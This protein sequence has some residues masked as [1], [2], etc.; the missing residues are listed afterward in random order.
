MLQDGLGDFDGIR[1]I[2]PSRAK[3]LRAMGISSLRDL[4]C[5]FPQS[6]E[7]HR[8][9]LTSDGRA[10]ETGVAEGIIS[11]CPGSF[12]F[13]GTSRV[14]AVLETENQSIRL[15]WFNQPW[16]ARSL[17][18]KTGIRL[19]GR[20]TR[21]D[22]IP[23]MVN[24]RLINDED[25]IPVYRKIQGIPGKMLRNWMEIALEKRHVL[26]PEWMPEKVIHDFHLIS[27]EE[28]VYQ[29]HFPESDQ[30]LSAARRRLNCDGMITYLSYVFRH[31]QRQDFG[32]P[33]QITAA[34]EDEYWN[35]LPFHPTEGQRRALHDIAE[36]LT[37]RRSMKR[38]L[39][40]DV[41]CGKTAVAFGAIYL[42]WKNGHQSSMMA[43]TEILAR[44]HYL[45][46]AR[47][48]EPL[49]IHCALL[50]SDIRGKERKEILS[51]LEKGQ[52]H[53][54]FGTHALISQ[55]VHFQD[56]Q[57]TITDEQHRFGVLQR[58]ALEKKGAVSGITYPHVL[59]MSATPIPRS[60]ALILY[61]DLEITVIDELPAGRIPVKTRIVPEEK[62][63]D[64]YRFLTDVVRQGRQVYMVCP[65]VE[66]TEA[67]SDKEE[68]HPQ[69]SVQ[70][71]Y[72]DLKHGALSGLKLGIT[73]GNQKSDE[74]QNVLDR[75]MQGEIQ[76]L[77]STTVIEVGVN[78]P[79]ASIMIIENAER[80][81]LSQLHQLRG[82]V[83]RG[84]EESWC[85]LMTD[86]EE[87]LRILCDTTDGFLISRKDLEIRG[88]GDLMG[89]RQ[90][91]APVFPGVQGDLRLLGEISE[92]LKKIRQDPDQSDIID[93]L[94]E[95]AEQC[96]TEAKHTIALN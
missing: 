61:G 84:K 46:A 66:E 76:V 71:L 64:M 68:F 42:A 44:Q 7:D 28:A 49:G 8:H 45:N 83:G 59:V 82:R 77:I 24:P 58:S 67:E 27:L 9:L 75:F 20:I 3:A 70:G 35:T 62:R 41:G 94:E 40:G 10:D 56:L 16:M 29:I 73:W 55:T 15:C 54:L 90:S 12:Y 13:H 30:Q 43:P 32:I 5:F 22:G 26:F 57:L 23:R 91:G 17:P 78:N 37:N 65:K 93:R 80:F 34:E 88:P 48:L 21:Q 11:K 89:T 95:H 53:V 33:F 19:Y 52:I 86:N 2:G 50:T 25:I 39:Q 4:L 14:T 92:Y 31:K 38:L 63:A 96:F 36:D 51:R 69:K 74:K 1:G 87:K 47:T 85:F 18:L 6:Y 79:N 60:L 72:Q 81:G